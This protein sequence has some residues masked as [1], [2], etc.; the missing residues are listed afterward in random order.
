[1]LIII[2]ETLAVLENVKKSANDINFPTFLAFGFRDNLK[3]EYRVD[4]TAARHQSMFKCILKQQ[5]SEISIEV[6][7]NLAMTN[8]QKK[9]KHCRNVHTRN[10]G[11]QKIREHVLKELAESVCHKSMSKWKKEAIIKPNKIPVFEII[12]HISKTFLMRKENWDDE[13][14]E[15][16]SSLRAYICISKKLT[17]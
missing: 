10:E 6:V 17:S 14:L 15:H 12:S 7:H 16:C 9:S 3:S 2:P 5:Y 4:I 11:L 13:F 1:M 8:N